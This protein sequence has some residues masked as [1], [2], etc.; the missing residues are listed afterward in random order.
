[1]RRK[2]SLGRVFYGHPGGHEGP[3]ARKKEKL[4]EDEVVSFEM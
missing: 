3:G 1:M 2:E 4:K